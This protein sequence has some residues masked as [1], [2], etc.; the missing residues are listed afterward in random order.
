[1]NRHCSLAAGIT[2]LVLL[3]IATVALVGGLAGIAQ[4]DT[5][6][7]TVR[8]VVV[9]SNR[10]HVQCTTTTLDGRDSIRFFAVSTNNATVANRLMTIGTTTL[11][12]GRRFIAIFN[13]G[14]TS[15]DAFDCIHEDCRRLT[16]FGIE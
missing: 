14:D 10:V 8:D 7:C 3:A 9:W 12:A 11:V 16:A 2:G 5:F 4:A 13:N 1:M 6:R 15:G